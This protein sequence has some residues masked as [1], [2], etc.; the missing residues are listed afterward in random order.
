MYCIFVPHTTVTVRNM[1][2]GSTIGTSRF[3]PGGQSVVNTASTDFV[4]KA[5]ERRG[6]GVA[7]YG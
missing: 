1:S 4:A 5:K 2:R 7:T 6:V 3:G